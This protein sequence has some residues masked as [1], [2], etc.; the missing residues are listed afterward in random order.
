[1]R[2]FYRFGLVGLVGFCID[3]LIFKLLFALLPTALE[4]RVLSWLFAVLFTY[5][6]N[7]VITFSQPSFSISRFPGDSHLRVALS[8]MVVAL[9]EVGR[10]VRKPFSQF[11]LYISFQFLGGTV[12]IAVFGFF[13]FILFGGHNQ[14]VAFIAGTLAGLGVNYFGAKLSIGSP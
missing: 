6:G 12:N 5:Y 14:F 2:P 3:F 11:L 1:M 7:S 4:A 10:V 9:R 8:A 13:Y